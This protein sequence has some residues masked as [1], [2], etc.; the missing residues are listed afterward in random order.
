MGTNL[1]LNAYP[2]LVHSMHVRHETSVQCMNC[3]PNGFGS[4][5]SLAASYPVDLFS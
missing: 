1:V 2:Q 3:T 5:G 4:F